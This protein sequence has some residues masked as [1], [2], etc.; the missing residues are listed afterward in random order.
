METIRRSR[1]D[2]LAGLIVEP[3]TVA[4]VASVAGLAVVA[5]TGHT[6]FEVA[7]LV[8]FLAGWSSAWSP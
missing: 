6:F 1:G 7:A 3:V 4:S 5:A 8:S 2:R